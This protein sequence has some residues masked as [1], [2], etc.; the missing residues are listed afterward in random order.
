[1][2]ATNLE[3]VFIYHTVELESLF[4]FSSFITYFGNSTHHPSITTKE[5]P[6]AA[7]ILKV[8]F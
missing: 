6:Q 2:A 1:M 3:T 5:K 7:L 4:Y 8:Y